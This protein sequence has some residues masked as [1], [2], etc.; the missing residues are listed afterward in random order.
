MQAMSDLL[1]ITNETI[2]S[3]IFTIRGKQVMVDRDLAKLYTTTTKALNQAVKRNVSR[4]PEKFCFQLDEVEKNGLVTNCDRFKTLKHSS[5]QINAFSEQG[6]A[7][8]SSVLR[9][10][11]AVK[12]SIQI[13][14]AF[15]EMRKFL[16]DNAEVFIR[17]ENVERK[18]LRADE[19]FD[20]IFDALQS[21]DLK[22][23][24]GIF[25]DGQVFDAYT[26]VA[27]LIREAKH[28]IVLIDNYVDDTVLKMFA[29]RNKNVALSIYTKKDCILSLDLAKYQT[30][31]GV[32]T[33]K[34]FKH[35]HDRFLIL[36]STTVYHIGA[37][38]KD[39]G[40]KWFAFSKMEIG[41]LDILNKL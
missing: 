19:K 40:K 20:K 32:I 4:F 34:E 2:Q 21:N 25:Y 28:S 13:M 10:E 30:Q 31:Y 9:S 37:S 39:L 35:A 15:V 11:I 23:K 38:L 24:Q 26:F 41:A 7:M 36:D 8:L 14:D 1:P 12:I 18:Q 29:K 22:P 5:Y 17:L 6:I 16:K 3:Q 27:D 33:V